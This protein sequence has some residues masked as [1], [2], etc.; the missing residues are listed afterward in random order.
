MP[1]LHS[2]SA[3]LQV[4][5]ILKRKLWVLSF[6][7]PSVVLKNARYLPEGSLYLH[8]VPWFLKLPSRKHSLIAGSRGQKV[9]C[10]SIQ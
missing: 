5:G 8:L 3:S 1:S 9:L 2:P 6:C 4:A 10:S 7:P